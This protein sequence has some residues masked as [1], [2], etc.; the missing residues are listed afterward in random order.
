MV[1]TARAR[2]QAQAGL[3]GLNEAG[4]IG[5]LLGAFVLYYALPWWP[6]SLVALALCAWLCYTQLPL[7]VS[8][9]PL[10]V[11]F[12]MLPKHLGRLEFSLGETAIVLCAGAFVLRRILEPDD[13][14]L[15]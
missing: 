15:Q 2:R 9:I 7:A 6:L 10:A 14:A 12:Y 5:L 13:G 3:A 11:P 1:A 4:R 8:L